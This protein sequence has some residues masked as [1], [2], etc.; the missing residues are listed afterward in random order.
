MSVIQAQWRDGMIPYIVF[1]GDYRDYF[2]G[3]DVWR[4]AGG[5]SDTLP[6]SGITNPPI[7]AFAVKM[8]AH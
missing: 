6:T 1:R 4:A 3:P 7:A 5:D 2:P 8:G